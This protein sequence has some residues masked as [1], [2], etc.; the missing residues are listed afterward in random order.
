[1][2]V[3]IVHHPMETLGVGKLLGHV[4]QVPAKIHAAPALADITKD[5]PGRHY[6]GGDQAARAV[7]NVLELA[8]FRPTCFHRP[9]R[10]LP[11]EGLDAGLFIDRQHQLV[12][13]VQARGIEIEPGDVQGFCFKVGVVAVQPLCT[14]VRLEVVAVENPV[15]G[16]ATHLLV[17]GVLDDLDRQVVQRP[18]RD[19]QIQ[20]GRLGGRQHDDLMPIF[21][22]KKSSEH[23][24][25]EGRPSR[26]GVR[27]RSVSA[28]CPP[29]RR[30]NRILERPANWSDGRRDR[31][32]G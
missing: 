25:E 24:C 22:G 29:C 26:R 9:T 5:L 14:A 30:R 21:R 3:E 20:L 4:P 18:V 27:Q 13:L 17:V 23:H 31:N 11:L 15:D 1:M 7:A 6:Q 28:T 12:V 16:T 32:A 10:I 19:R 8:T 2:R